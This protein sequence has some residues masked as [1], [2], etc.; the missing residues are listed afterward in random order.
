MDDNKCIDWGKSY[1]ISN[2]YLNKAEAVPI[3][4]APWS[5]VWKFETESGSIY[6]KKSIPEFSIEAKIITI[7]DRVE[8]DF[9]PKVI[10]INPDLNCFLMLDAG[11]PLR[12]R[13]RHKFDMDILAEVVNKY[14]RLQCAISG[15]SDALIEAGVPD[16][17]LNQLPMLYANLIGNHLLL[18]EV[19]IAPSEKA[20]LIALK[21]KFIEICERLSSFKIP[22]TLNHCDFHDNNV[23]YDEKNHHLT[24]MDLVEVV[25][26]HPFLSLHSLFFMQQYWNY[27]KKDDHDYLKLKEVCFHH[28]RQFESEKNLQEIFNLTLLL[29]PLFYVF[30]LMR[31]ITACDKEGYRTHYTGP[32]GLVKSLQA[33]K[34]NIAGCLRQ[35]MDNDNTLA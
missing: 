30:S 23:L 7:I 11:V 21:P 2:G 28:F 16:W 5:M 34:K 22:E 15:Q 32:E 8:P 13:F 6:L 14:T 29:H 3:T 25:I 4:I 26:S 1:L 9:V 12:E 33:Q 17:R 19:G 10:A 35:F 24:L 27:F 31:L 20:K 18:D